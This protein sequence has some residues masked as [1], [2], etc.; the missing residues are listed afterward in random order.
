MACNNL[1]NTVTVSRLYPEIGE[2]STL[3]STVVNTGTTTEYFH[4]VFTADGV[5]FAISD[6][7]PIAPGETIIS[8]VDFKAVTEG[9]VSLC[10]DI[11]C[12]TPAT[13]APVASF[14]RTPDTYLREGQVAQFTDTSTGDPS[15]WL[16][17]FGDGATSTLQNPTHVYTDW[18]W[19]TVTLTVTNSLGTNTRTWGDCICGMPWNAPI[20]SFTVTPSSGV[21]PLIV[22]ATNTSQAYPG[23][24]LQQRWY[25]DGTPTTW[26]V[27]STITTLSATQTYTT[28][29][30]HTIRME[31]AIV[32]SASWIQAPNKNVIVT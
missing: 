3:I 18:N 11:I 29:G 28:A 32:G 16:W 17:N 24:T 22:T 1:N 7:T 5:Q 15:G 19:F 2:Y 10:A 6:V 30:T 26:G 14:T 8:D 25:L 12:D 20:P 9:T 13:V 27:L 21:H 23:T 4:I 31:A